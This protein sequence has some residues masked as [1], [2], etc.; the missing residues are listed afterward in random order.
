M[1]L[2][3]TFYYMETLIL[4]SKITFEFNDPIEETNFLWETFDFL[5]KPAYATIG[6]SEL[7]AQ[8]SEV[9][10]VIFEIFRMLRSEANKRKLDYLQKIIINGIVCWCID[11]GDNGSIALML[12]SEY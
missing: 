7:I 11:S 8:K 6:V 4:N 9:Q 3:F 1:R 12:P 10:P 2:F 5:S